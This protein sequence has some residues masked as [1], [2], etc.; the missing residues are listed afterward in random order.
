MKKDE[1]RLRLYFVNEH[2]VLDAFVGKGDTQ[3][4]VT[5]PCLPALPD[6]ARVIDVHHDFYRKQF[7]FMVESATFEPVADGDC[8]PNAARRAF[9]EHRVLRIVRQGEPCDDPVYA[10]KEA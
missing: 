6:D 4:Y 1:R 8:I 9:V 7:A 5:L 3:Q 10:V 2:D